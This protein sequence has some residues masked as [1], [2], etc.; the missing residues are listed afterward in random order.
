MMEKNGVVK[1]TNL[2]IRCF[3]PSLRKNKLFKTTRKVQI[4]IKQSPVG[5]L[6]FL[7]GFFQRMISQIDTTHPMKRVQYKRRMR[8]VNSAQLDRN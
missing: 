8:L 2:S 4:L 5:C 3:R 7:L 1:Q 6:F